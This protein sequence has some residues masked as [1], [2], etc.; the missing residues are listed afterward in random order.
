MSDVI[1]VSEAEFLLVDA[2]ATAQQVSDQIVHIEVIE[3]GAQGPAG[4]RGE[5]GIQGPQGAPGE[6][7]V[8]GL[9]GLPGVSD[10]HY[11]HTQNAP[12]TEWNV[13]HGLFKYP[14]VAVLDSA[15]TLIDGGIEHLSTSQTRLTFS[16]AFSGKAIFN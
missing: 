4:P 12:A 2:G 6:L 13:M 10:K 1:V 3:A 11:T 15:G 14:S 16:S 9:Q 7:G 8:Q 5:Q